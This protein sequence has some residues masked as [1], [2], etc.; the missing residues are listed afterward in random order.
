[1]S[2]A[3]TE[4]DLKARHRARTPYKL[5]DGTRVP[6]VTTI[7][8]ELAKPALI[9]WAWNLGMQGINYK[10]YVDDL[11]RI[12]TLTHA[13]IL[14]DLRGQDPEDMAADDEAAVIA[15]DPGVRGLAENC[16]LSFLNWKAKHEVKPVAL[17]QPLV[18]EV[19]RYG[20]KSDFLGWVDGQMEVIDFKTGK[21]VYPEH[22][23]QLSAY[24]V[25]LTE[26]NI[27]PKSI[28]RH[29]VVNIPR[30]DS[31]AFDDKVRAALAPE[32]KIFQAALTIYNA[33]KEMDR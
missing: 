10:D 1:M 28:D 22:F 13:M 5:A 11:A 26:N 32:W 31:E 18:S 19:Y 12:G 4:K 6:S 30:A 2:A 27:T 16:Y 8:G 24:A 33:K 21:R 29:R 25:L 9:H 17:E 7:L 3:A 23:I 14:N 15:R 20:G